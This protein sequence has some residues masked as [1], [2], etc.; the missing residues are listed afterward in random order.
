MV[1]TVSSEATEA[2]RRRTRLHRPL[3]LLLGLALAAAAAG[4]AFVVHDRFDAVSPL[5]IAVA[6]GAVFANVAS[7]PA[8]IR[9]GVQFAAKRLLRWG[10]VLLGFQLSLSQLRALGLPGLG[11]VA[12]TV[13]VTFF[14]TQWI[15][16]RLGLS[17]G[18]SLLVATG[19]SICGASAIA[20]VEGL[21]DAEEEEVAFSIALV[22]LCGSLAIVVLPALGPLVGLHGIAY[23]NWVGASVHDIGQVV[24]AA[25]PGGTGAVNAAVVV[26][27]TRVM[28]LA[29][30][31]AGLS[32]ARRRPAGSGPN[33]ASSAKR[34]AAVPLFVLGFL[35]AVIVRTTGILPAGALSALKQA[36][37]ALLAAALFGLGC[38]VQ[39]RRLKKVGG[40]P[41]VLG[42]VSWAVVAGMALTGS[43]LLPS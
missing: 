21:A 2:G 28:L 11:V 10:V 23:G 35:G 33:A 16:A 1:M 12:I 8:Q 18:M 31:V 29:P 15:G 30:L 42:L 36:Q 32:L 6:L 9:P 19:F 41:L 40:R 26:K 17:N 24:A 14:G 20:A 34:P 38:G 27:L 25:T 5:I 7:S 39:I 13:A 37:T 3:E 43:H 22:T 4:V